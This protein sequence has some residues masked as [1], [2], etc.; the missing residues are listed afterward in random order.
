MKKL[1][2]PTC[3]LGLFSFSYIN[4]NE[5]KAATTVHTVTMPGGMTRFPLNHFFPPKY[6]F[7]ANKSYR[8]EINI[9][10]GNGNIYTCINNLI[11][12]P[13]GRQCVLPSP[14]YTKDYTYKNN[15]FTPSKSGDLKG[16]AFTGQQYIMIPRAATITVRITPL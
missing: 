11:F 16:P 15:I 7:Q 1:L 8:L 5:A 3:L 6:N 12:E 4:F 2:I 14:K 13:E 10:S 9:P